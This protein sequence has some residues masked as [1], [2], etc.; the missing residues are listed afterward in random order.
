MCACVCFCPLLRTRAAARASSPLPPF[1]T[2]ASIIQ[3]RFRVEGGGTLSPAAK[4]PLPFPLSRRGRHGLGKAETAWLYTM[5]MQER[6]GGRRGI[7]I[8]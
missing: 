7:D 4:L 6:E 5:Y 2:A 3:F 1:S 8:L